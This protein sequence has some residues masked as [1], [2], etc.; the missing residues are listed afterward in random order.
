MALTL[1]ENEVRA[2][3]CRHCGDLAAKL[4][5]NPTSISNEEVYK[6]VERMYDL[7]HCIVLTYGKENKAVTGP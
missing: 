7:A 5:Y 1:D 3:I 2:V 6:T 4:A